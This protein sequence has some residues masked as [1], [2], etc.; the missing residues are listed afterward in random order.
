MFVCRFGFGWLVCGKNEDTTTHTSHRVETCLGGA[1]A[2][3]FA[4]DSVGQEFHLAE[5]AKRGLEAAVVLHGELKIMAL[6]Q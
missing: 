5:L 1:L 3:L 4:Q 2:I 6:L